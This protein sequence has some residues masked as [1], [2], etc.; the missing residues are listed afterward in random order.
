[1]EGNLEPV[2]QQ[3][4]RKRWEETWGLPVVS[5]DRTYMPEDVTGLCWRDE[6]G[7]PQGLISW[8]IEGDRAEIVTLDAYQQGR[9]IGG[10]LLHGAEMELADRGVRHICIVTTNDNLRAIAF[11]VRRGYR[12]IRVDL[13]SMDRVRKLKPSVPP[14]GIDN[15][16]LR[17]MF[18]LQKDLSEPVASGSGSIPEGA[19]PE[20]FI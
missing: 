1:M 3:F 7:E 9:H 13:D 6:W 10:R 12:I 15:I 17:D 8:H 14:R 5:I 2:D 16:P 20:S 11:Y 19:R 4:I 18:E